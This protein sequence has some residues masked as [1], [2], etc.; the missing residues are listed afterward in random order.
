LGKGLALSIATRLATALL[1][2]SLAGACGNDKSGP[3]PVAAA[4]GSM[5]KASVA[6][7]KAKKSGDTPAADRVT[8]ADLEKYGTPILRFVAKPL[9]QDGFLTISD[10]KGDV[11]T[12]S[13]SNGVT[14]SLRNGVLIQTRGL[15]PDLMS[16]QVPTVAQLST[17][18]GTYQRIYFFLGADDR[19]T[20]RTL[21]CTTTV[22]GRKT[23]TV[24]GRSHEV[25]QISEVCTRSTSQ[26][27]ND[28]WIEGG[29][30]RKSRQW[31][32]GSIGHIDFVRVID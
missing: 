6:K 2:L 13:T 19:P 5:A 25:T 20:R 21:D 23:I 7:V 12:W 9:D 8:R 3:N 26:I 32:S 14:F 28:Y 24:F 15:G 30:I 27:T 29:S 31:T 10:Q 11:V 22:V 17:P 16:A 18:G 1:A 4:L